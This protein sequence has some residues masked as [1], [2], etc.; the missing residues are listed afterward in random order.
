MTYPLR[1]V[2]KSEFVSSKYCRPGEGSYFFTLD[3][4]HITVSKAS[5]GQPKRKRCRDCGL[6]MG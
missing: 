1:K 2:V 4:G 3:C 5:N 6:G